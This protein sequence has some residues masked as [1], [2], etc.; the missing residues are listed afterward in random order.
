MQNQVKSKRDGVIPPN[1][2]QN[3]IKTNLN[4]IKH[5]TLLML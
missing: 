2:K 1:K 5:E 3:K 4:P